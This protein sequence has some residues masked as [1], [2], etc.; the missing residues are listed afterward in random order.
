MAS[1]RGNIKAAVELANHYGASWLVDSGSTTDLDVFVTAGL[2][3]Y[4]AWTEQLRQ[5][6]VNAFDQVLFDE[7]RANDPEV[8]N[9][10]QQSI[11]ETA[12]IFSITLDTSKKYVQLIREAR[13]KMVAHNP[14]QFSLFSETSKDA[15]GRRRDAFSLEELH[16]WDR[17]VH[18]LSNLVDQSVLNWA[19]W[20]VQGKE[21]EPRTFPI[22]VCQKRQ[23]R[24]SADAGLN[25]IYLSPDS[26][27]DV[28]LHE[29]IHL[30][31]GLDDTISRAN[32]LYLLRRT[33]G[34]K[35]RKKLA[36][37]GKGEFYAKGGFLK[38]YTG[39]ISQL[40]A[41]EIMTTSVPYLYFDPYALAKYDP[42]TFRH[43]MFIL[44]RNTRT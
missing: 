42:E 2:G 17:A 38:E 20:P 18:F 29:A 26:R 36:T 43:V 19:D 14:V 12:W 31:E 5:E 35:S 6:I 1:Y 8:A 7:M 33:N 15:F 4:P 41:T 21:N 37:S 27:D 3:D 25:T 44:Q 24:A 39:K 40:G 16:Q 22:R 28:F 30:I 9:R 11:Y 10:E 32:Y 23:Q 34:M 13:A